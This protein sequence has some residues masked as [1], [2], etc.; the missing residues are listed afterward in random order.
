MYFQS[1]NG[2]AKH[3]FQIIYDAESEYQVFLAI[4]FHLNVVYIEFFREFL[5]NTGITVM[6]FIPVYIKGL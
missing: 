4:F 5:H 3:F 6:T 2:T 1:E